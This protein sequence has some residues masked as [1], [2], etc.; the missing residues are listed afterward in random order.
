MSVRNMKI[1]A[2][3]IYGLCKYHSDNIYNQLTSARTGQELL[4]SKSLSEITENGSVI[5]LR[6]PLSFNG[7]SIYVTTLAISHLICYF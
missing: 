5:R 7:I 4:S 1:P 3:P 2:V 6:V